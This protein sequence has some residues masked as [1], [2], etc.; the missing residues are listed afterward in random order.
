MRSRQ[1]T[2]IAREELAAVA[3]DLR[4]AKTLDAALANC[5][6]AAAAGWSPHSNQEHRFDLSDDHCELLGHLWRDCSPSAW[7]HVTWNGN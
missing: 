7:A 2:L 1:V 5:N 6:A 3:H 4:A